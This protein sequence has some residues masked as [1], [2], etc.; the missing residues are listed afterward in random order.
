MEQYI[1]MKKLLLALGFL[2]WSSAAFAQCTGV[3]PPNSLCGNL[4]GS[5]APPSQF[6]ASGT[7]VGPV[8]STLNGL[9]LWANTLG[10]QLKDG[11]GQTVAGAYTWSGAQTYSATN[12]YNGIANFVSTFQINGN[13]I[14]FPGVVA[15]LA[16]LA[17]SQ[18]YTGNNIWSGNNTYQTG[19]FNFTGT[20]QIGG[21]TVTLPISATNGGTGVASPTAHSVP[22]NE[23]SSAQANTGVGTTGQYLGGNTSADPS[24]KSGP[25]TLICSLNASN[26]TSLDD[27]TCNS[28]GP[29]ITTAF[30]DYWISLENIVPVI[31]TAVT[32]QLQLY[33]GGS[34]I[35]VNYANVYTQSN[36]SSTSFGGSGSQTNINCSIS[37]TI[38]TPGIGMDFYIKNANGGSVAKIVTYQGG[39]LISA[40]GSPRVLSGWAANTN[41]GS[42]TGAHLTFSSGNISIGLMKIYGR[43]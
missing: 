10:T 29:A 40:A 37:E 38:A 25:W 5:P 18:T 3:F 11:A 1:A 30:N 28:G 7:I 42:I 35:T 8:S 6:S 17:G 33:I 16:Y 23:G 14:T 9:S 24:Y 32:C 2:L 36:T 20:F 41:T 31:G 13:A 39:Y 15:T 4:T 27:Q 19:T 34:L 26:S 12:T 22:I 21:S 43:L